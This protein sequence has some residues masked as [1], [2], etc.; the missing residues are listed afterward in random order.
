MGS[1]KF[2]AG[3]RFLAEITLPDPVHAP[4]IALRSDPAMALAK[5]QEK[6]VKLQ[7]LIQLNS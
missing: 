1:I 3:L 5:L 6:A 2:L 4:I 7:M